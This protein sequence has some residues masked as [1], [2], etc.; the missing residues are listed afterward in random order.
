MKP[1]LSLNNWKDAV[2]KAWE[3]FDSMAIG[4]LTFELLDNTA[5]AELLIAHYNMP[6]V[7]LA[8]GLYDKGKG[9]IYN[10]QGELIS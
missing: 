9:S 6:H 1:Y 10:E 3:A 5:N 7:K 4:Y 2:T 8:A